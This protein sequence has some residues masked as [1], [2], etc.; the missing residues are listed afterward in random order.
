LDRV[1]NNDAA[2]LDQT[3]IRIYLKTPA[4]IARSI[5]TAT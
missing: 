3:F 4:A 2:I 1:A 5:Q